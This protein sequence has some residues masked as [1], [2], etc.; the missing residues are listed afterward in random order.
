MK[1]FSEI[2]LL[3]LWNIYGL[4]KKNFFCLFDYL[5]F[6]ING[7]E[8]GIRACQ[9]CCHCCETLKNHQTWQR[10]IIKKTKA[11]ISVKPFFG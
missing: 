8:I 2:K 5:S 6:Q 4:T 9:R 10:G 3:T 11:K 1:I 7:L